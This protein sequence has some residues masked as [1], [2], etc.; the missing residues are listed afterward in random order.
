MSNG[1][2]IAATTRT[3]RNLLTGATPNVTTLPVDRARD[4]GTADQLN[5]FLYA[6]VLSAA[7]RN[8][9]PVG[10][11]PGESGQPPLPLVLHYLITAYGDDEALA[12]AV[13]GRAMSILHGHPVLDGQEIKDAT[14][15]DLPDSDLHLQPERLRLTPLA[16]STDDLFKLWS[17]FSTNYRVSAAYE[18]S[19]VLIDSR[20]DAR[21]PLPVLRV[22]SDDR[23]ARA[24]AAPAPELTAVLPAVG[25]MVATLGAHIRLIG[26]NLGKGVTA[27]R[28]RNLRLAAP[29][30][31]PCEGGGAQERT[32]R[33]PTGDPAVADWTPGVYTVVLVSARPGVPVAVSDAV[34]MALGAHIMVAPLAVPA[35]DVTLTITCLPRLRDSARVGVLLADRQVL[36][37]R[38]ITPADPTQPSTVTATFPSV[39]SGSYVVR[40]RVDGVD[41]DPVRYAGSPPL[42]QFDP[43]VQVVVA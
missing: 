21:S 37:T 15:V 28:F 34:P 32:V 23:G 2:A 6:T 14:A 17:G 22:G 11:R 16:I 30:E 13:L 4:S 12:Q 42:P 3:L 33:L 36:P 39:R 10:V 7:W 31:L 18:V 27:V 20:R 29:I 40:L 9:D 26:A 19:P 35:G 41:S 38:I 1:L 8:A 5:L 24:V 43:A 25:T